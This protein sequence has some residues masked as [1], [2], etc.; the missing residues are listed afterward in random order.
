MDGKYDGKSHKVSFLGTGSVTEAPGL[1]AQVS[2]V[3]QGPVGNF[4]A[5]PDKLA[6]RCLLIRPHMSKP[7]RVAASQSR[8]RKHPNIWDFSS[9]LLSYQS[10]SGV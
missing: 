3:K 8:L 4:V 7:D 10:E 1:F 6:W 2:G 5:V 9:C